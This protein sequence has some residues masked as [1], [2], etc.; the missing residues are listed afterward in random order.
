M[1]TTKGFLIICQG[2]PI[3]GEMAYN[4]AVTLRATGNHFPICLVYNDSAISRLSKEQHNFFTDKILMDEHFINIRL[5]LPEITPY[6]YTLALDCD[7]L[8]LNKDAGELF[9]ILD[10]IDFTVENFGYINTNGETDGDNEYLHWANFEDI[11]NAYPIEG[12]LYKCCNSFILFK[13]SEKVNELFKLWAEI[14]SQPKCKYIEW[15]NSC[16][17][18]FSLNIAL[19]LLKLEP[20]K[21]RWRVGKWLLGDATYFPI[22]HHAKDYYAIN[23]G[24]NIKTRR[25]IEYYNLTA[26]AAFDK[27]NLP[28]NFKLKS[29]RDHIKERIKM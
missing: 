14:Q 18:E 3:Y 25:D 6:D 1:K 2:N 8:W 29:K 12:R 19:N 22:S 20:H 15:C 23:A 9:N 7:L 11:E 27:L 10:S 13:K 5:K 17:D 26:Q 28:F 24:G 21:S 4:L 16:P